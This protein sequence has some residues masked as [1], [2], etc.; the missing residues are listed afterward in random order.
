MKRILII[1]KKLTGFYGAAEFTTPDDPIALD[2]NVVETQANL[3]LI[4]NS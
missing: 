4:E 2:S 3:M 1:T